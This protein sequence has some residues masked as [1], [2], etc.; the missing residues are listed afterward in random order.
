MSSYGIVTDYWTGEQIRPATAQEWRRTADLVSG[1]DMN[2]PGGYTGAWDD[3]GRAVWVD[4]GPVAEISADDVRA[5]LAE[6]GSAGDGKMAALCERALIDDG[7]QESYEA[8]RECARVILD[9]RQE[10]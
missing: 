7:S 8:G 3:D 1:A 9:N 6:A 10:S 4:G 5:L 2:K